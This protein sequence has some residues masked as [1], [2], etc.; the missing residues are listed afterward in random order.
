MTGLSMGGTSTWRFARKKYVHGGEGSC[1]S[2]MENEGMKKRRLQCESHRCWKPCAGILERKSKH[3]LE[4]QSVRNTN[5][6]SIY[7]NWSHWHWETIPDMDNDV[8]TS[9]PGYTNML[10]AWLWDAIG[11]AVWQYLLIGKWSQGSIPRWPRPFFQLPWELKWLS[12]SEEYIQ[13]H[14]SQMSWP[15]GFLTSSAHHKRNVHKNIWIMQ[16]SKGISLS[17]NQK[18]TKALGTVVVDRRMSVP[19]SMDRKAYMGPWRMHSLGTWMSSWLHF[20]RM[21]GYTRDEK[22]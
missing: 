6:C 4:D 17:W 11:P 22:G 10:T 21:R 1:Q 19:A 18:T 8:S 13:P 16:A 5:E 9:Q 14:S 12:I 2:D 20:S 7:Q 3:S 15:A